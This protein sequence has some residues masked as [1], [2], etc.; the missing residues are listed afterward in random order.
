MAPRYVM[1][2]GPHGYIP[3]CSGCVDEPSEDAPAPGEL[4]IEA[5]RDAQEAIRNDR[6]DR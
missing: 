4:S 3:V 5:H 6:W 1:D 2:R